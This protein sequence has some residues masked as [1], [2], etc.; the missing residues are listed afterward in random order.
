MYSPATDLV[1][2]LTLT[3]VPNSAKESFL[4]FER[5][6]VDFWM[7]GFGFS[8]CA[9]PAWPRLMGGGPEAWPVPKVCFAEVGNLSA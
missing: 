6:R 5:P 1:N 2:A 3:E 9:G 7:L 4:E 8:G